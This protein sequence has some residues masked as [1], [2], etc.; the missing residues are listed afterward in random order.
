MPLNVK[1]GAVSNTKKEKVYC[2]HAATKA[3]WMTKFA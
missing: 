2:G 3:A 1:M